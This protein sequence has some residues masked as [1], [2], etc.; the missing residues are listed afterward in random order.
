MKEQKDIFISYRRKDGSV[1]AE[2]VAQILESQG[3][4]VFFDKDSIRFGSSFPKVL[5]DAVKDCNELIAIVTRNY[6]NDK[7]KRGNRRIDSDVDW[8]RNELRLALE[9]NKQ[10]F[11]IYVTRPPKVNTLPTDIKSVCDK[12]SIFY[13]RVSDTLSSIIARIK[14]DF[15]NDTKENALLGSILNRLKE[16]NVKDNKKFNMACKDIIKLLTTESDME[17]LYR[18]LSRKEENK[19]ATQVVNNKD[20]RF[21]V[22]YTLLTYYR[23]HNMPKRLID[24][25]ENYGN[26]FAEYPF[27]HYVMTE[28]YLESAKTAL[29]N[30]TMVSS[31]LK[32]IEYAKSAIYHISDNNGIIHSLPFTVATALE[33]GVK[34][35]EEDI[36]QSLTN[37]NNVIARAP[38]YG[39]MY[40]STK[41]R[42]LGQLGEYEEALKY[43]RLAQAME[44]PTH[45]DWMLR[46][47]TYQKQEIEIML[48]AKIN[49]LQ[50]E[51]D[52]IKNNH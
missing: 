39:G 33:F 5:E 19:S 51:I 34:V 14:V 36:H 26:E 31:F 28:Y 11:P 1:L 47:A 18:I 49:K 25:V 9:N 30:E 32:A 44:T 20:F 3:F 50:K 17:S 43:I 23:R 48:K 21:V 42:L 6:F 46:I 35:P 52:N 7:D 27:Y 41:A 13:N 10:I 22:L 12:H 37:I 29:T 40:Y 15:S 38:Y 4:H 16:V 8:V 2:A 24:M 45:N